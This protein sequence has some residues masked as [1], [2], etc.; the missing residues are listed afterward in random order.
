MKYAGIGG[1]VLLICLFGSRAQTIQ[2]ASQ[3]GVPSPTTYTIVSQDAN[4]R[5]WKSESY[6]AGQNGVIG[7]NTRSYKELAKGLNYL[8]NREWTPSEEQ[9][10]ILPNGIAE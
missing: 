1:F 8:S 9:I 7:T 4:S 3:V 2:G 5:V 10:S 6:E